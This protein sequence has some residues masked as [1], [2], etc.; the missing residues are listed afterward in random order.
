VFAEVAS[1]SKQSIGCCAQPR[2]SGT[3]LGDQFRLHHVYEH[4][5]SVEEDEKVFSVFAAPPN[6]M[7]GRLRTREEQGR[8]DGKNSRDNAHP[9]RSSFCLYTSGAIYSFHMSTYEPSED[10]EQF[11]LILLIIIVDMSVY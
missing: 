7:Q 5:I 3:N 8:V 9:F 2:C 11:I 4:L 1:T 6:S 10:C